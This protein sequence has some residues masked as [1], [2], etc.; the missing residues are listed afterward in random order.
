MQALESTVFFGFFRVHDLKTKARS[1]SYPR[2]S[3]EG[4]NPPR[5]S[6]TNAFCLGFGCSLVDASLRWHDEMGDF[7]GL[8][9]AKWL[10]KF[11]PDS[12]APS[13]E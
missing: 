12:S 3:C 1:I 5:D 8:E 9:Q 13:R 11:I 7:S 10:V 4:R 6:K 2:H